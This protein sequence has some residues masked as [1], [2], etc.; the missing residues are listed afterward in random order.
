[1]S[2]SGDL[3]LSA[4]ILAADLVI[5]WIRAP[6]GR[7]E[8]LGGSERSGPRQVAM[9]DELGDTG[10]PVKDLSHRYLVTPIEPLPVAVE[11]LVNASVL[12]A[13]TNRTTGAP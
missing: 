12:E 2:N 8:V 13:H 4:I 11:S 1:V 3:H 5:P 9:A 6:G 10:Y 7:V